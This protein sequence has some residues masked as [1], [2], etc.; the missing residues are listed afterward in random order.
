M[1]SNDEEETGGNTRFP[2]SIENQSEI[3]QIVDLIRNHLVRMK[4]E[5]VESC[6]SNS[7]GA[8]APTL[9]YKRSSGLIWI[10]PNMELWQLRVGGH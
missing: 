5:R 9:N 10:S 4:S 6:G 1:D 7:I 2:L 8:K 3:K